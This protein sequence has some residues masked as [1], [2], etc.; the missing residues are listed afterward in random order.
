MPNP[1]LDSLP[2]SLPNIGFDQF[3][4]STK[5]PESLANADPLIVFIRSVGSDESLDGTE[6]NRQD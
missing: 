1:P 6:L 2:C 5:T 3:L 4:S